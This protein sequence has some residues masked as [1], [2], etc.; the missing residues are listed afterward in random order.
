MAVNVTPMVQNYFG[1]W[2]YNGQCSCKEG[3]AGI[4]CVK[5]RFLAFAR[6]KV[7]N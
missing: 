5:F 2:K 7:T 6:R 1:M 4:K 3:F